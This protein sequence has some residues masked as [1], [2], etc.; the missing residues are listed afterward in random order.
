M[1]AEAVHGG[2]NGYQTVLDS[3]TVDSGP[4]YIRIR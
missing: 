2:W 1:A 3:V 4:V